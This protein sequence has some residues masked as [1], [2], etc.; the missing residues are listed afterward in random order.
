M[1]GKQLTPDAPS[2]IINFHLHS[3]SRQAVKQN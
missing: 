1:Q 2:T 3:E